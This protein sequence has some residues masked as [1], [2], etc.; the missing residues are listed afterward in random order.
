MSSGASNS[1][2]H[3]GS[4]KTRKA[5]NAKSIAVKT[6]V[7]FSAKSGSLK[8][9]FTPGPTSEEGIEGHRR[10]ASLRNKN[11]QTELALHAKCLGIEIRGRRD[12][13][14]PEKDCLEEIKTFYGEVERIP[15]NQQAL[16]WAQLKIYGWMWCLE[17]GVDDAHLALVYFNLQDEKE[18]RFEEHYSAK[19]LATYA[20]TLV[21]KYCQWQTLV[22]VRRERLVD[23][24]N[25]LTF[26]FAEMYP[27]QRYFAE[28]VYKAAA[29]G[30]VLLAEAPTGTGKTLATIFPAIKAFPHTAVD[31]IFY[32]TSKSTG[33]QLALNQLKLLVSPQ[34]DAASASLQPE[35]L[36]APLRILE[37]TALEKACLAP[38]KRCDGDDCV[39]AKDFYTKL[40]KV[41]LLAAEMPLLDKEHL[42]VLAHQFDICPFYLSMEMSRWV[43]VVVT[44]IN[45]YF[46]INALLFG[47]VKQFQW[48]PYLLVD[49]SHNLIDRSRSMY[50]AELER[51]LLFAAKKHL[52]SSLKKAADRVNRSWLDIIN[53]ADETEFSLLN[54]NLP[55]RFE[56]ALSDFINTYIQV[57]QQFPDHPMQKSNAHDFFF[58][59]VNFVQ[60]LEIVKNEE[61]DG[62]CLD[63]YAAADKQEVLTLRNVIPAGVLSARI[64]KAHCACFFLQRLYLSII[65]NS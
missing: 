27:P 14:C 40:E 21:R 64:K 24:S 12:G 26:P 11:Y 43:D 56:Y 19:D 5:S 6:L 51:R 60:L 47:L 15:E 33:K 59:L 61:F 57:L 8:R 35:E 52:P 37:I 2:Q 63:L 3:K 55:E 42:D 13:Y 50:T 45:Y 49:E 65:F 41:R 46:D 18:Y 28:T 44:D 10:L 7:D 53:K 58:S 29:L 38:D 22:E 1:L 54:N 48:K 20:K 17:M 62:F 23:W 30:K 36:P 25:K 9:N 4:P 32:L 39:F 16:H 34:Q 31:K